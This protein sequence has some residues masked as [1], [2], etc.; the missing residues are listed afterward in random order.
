MSGVCDWLVANQIHVGSEVLR[1]RAVPHTVANDGDVW[2]KTKTTL[3]SHALETRALMNR[4]NCVDYIAIISKP[5]DRVWCWEES[6]FTFTRPS[7]QRRRHAM[8]SFEGFRYRHSIPIKLC[9][10]RSATSSKIL[11]TRSMDIFWWPLANMTE[12]V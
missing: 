9:R 12:S 4:Y 1:S 11:K 6:R 2:G 7:T 3:W 10:A 8:T 5:F